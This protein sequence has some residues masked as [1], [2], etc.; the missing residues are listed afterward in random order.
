LLP[1]SSR[2]LSTTDFTDPIADIDFASRNSRDNFILYGYNSNPKEICYIFGDTSEL[3][4]HG[5]TNYFH[6]EKEIG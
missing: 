2:D 5:T 4:I 3:S 6:H 1:L